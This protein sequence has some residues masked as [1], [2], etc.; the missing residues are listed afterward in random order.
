[1]SAINR[2][3]I[4]MS[5]SNWE[6][7]L[8]ITHIPI[9]VLLI[10]YYYKYWNDIPEI[11]ISNNN[12]WREMPKQTHFTGSIGQ[13]ISFMM[14]GC[15]YIL[16]NPRNNPW[17]GKNVSQNSSKAIKQYR[18]ET[19]CLLCNFAIAHIFL[20]MSAI[21]RIEGQINRIYIPDNW[22]W[23]FIISMLLTWL[24]HHGLWTRLSDK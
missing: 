24:I 2:P 13:N 12:K 19:S 5:I 1:M 7:L 3:H 11:L 23:L 14:L 17:K 21:L 4:A 6:I 22:G 20:V 16:I 15:Y 18:I 8:L 9:S 10:L